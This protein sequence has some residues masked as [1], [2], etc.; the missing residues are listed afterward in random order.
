MRIKC[1]FTHSY[2]CNILRVESNDFPFEL[3]QNIFHTHIHHLK[4]IKQKLFAKRVIKQ[5]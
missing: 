4:K 1:A 2:I 5:W 3:H